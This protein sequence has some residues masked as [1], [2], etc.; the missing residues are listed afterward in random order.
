MTLSNEIWKDIP[1]FP[2]YQAS[3]MGRVR[4][5][6]HYVDM[7]N[8]GQTLKPM[9]IISFKLDKDGYKEYRLT[10]NGKRKHRR[11]HRLV[12]LTFIPNPN[13]LPVINH[14]NGIRDDNRVINLEWCTPSHNTKWAYVLGNKCQKGSNNNGAKLDENKVKQIKALLKT[15]IK[16][17]EI[18]KKFKVCKG[19]IND[20][21]R[22]K[23]WKHVEI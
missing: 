3:N 11:G 21:S 12:A 13:N 5:L 1:E 20:I 8:G 14:I 15:K 23:S 4:K 9:K 7:P 10:L 22:G 2:L 6:E 18:A 17:A 19:T 16:Q